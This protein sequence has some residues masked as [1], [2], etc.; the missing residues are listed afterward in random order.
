MKRSQEHRVG[1][2]TEILGTEFREIQRDLR[3]IGQKNIQISQEHRVEKHKRSQ[4][5]RVENYTE[6]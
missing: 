5:H 4:E 2:Y 3:N 1:K 6:I